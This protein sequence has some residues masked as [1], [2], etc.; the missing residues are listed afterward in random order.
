MFKLNIE[1]TEKRN[2]FHV[3]CFRGTSSLYVQ[4]HLKVGVIY[5]FSLFSRIL[6][7]KCFL[8]THFLFCK[9]PEGQQRPTSAS[10][11]KTPGTPHSLRVFSSPLSLSLPD[12]WKQSSSSTYHQQPWNPQL[13]HKDMFYILISMHVTTLKPQHPLFELFHSYPALSVTS[14]GGC[15][16]S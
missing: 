7:E 16:V 5:K 6:V 1:Q 14:D 11:H 2:A 3:L 12:V 9:I 10:L 8:I 4:K 13:E 15:N